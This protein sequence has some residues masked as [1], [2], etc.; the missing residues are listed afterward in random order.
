MSGILTVG[1]FAVWESPHHDEPEQV[2]VIRLDNEGRRARVRRDCGGECWAYFD[3]LEQWDGPE[4]HGE[5][6]G[7]R[8]RRGNI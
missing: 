2:Q 3:E 4:P 1:C 6:R 5:R 7:C 8:S